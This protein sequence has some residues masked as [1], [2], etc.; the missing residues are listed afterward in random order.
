MVVS[1]K[2]ALVPFYHE[3]VS[4]LPGK[5]SCL[6]TLETHIRGFRQVV[7]LNLLRHRCP[8]GHPVLAACRDGDEGGAQ[9]EAEKPAKTK[10]RARHGERTTTAAAVAAAAPG[11]DG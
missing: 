6:F 2:T 10:S 4:W 9:R 5:W 7:R 8:D 3:A 1:S 11:K